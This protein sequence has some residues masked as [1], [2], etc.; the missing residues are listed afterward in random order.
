MIYL[1]VI[2]H[3]VNNLSFCNDVYSDYKIIE[4][5]VPQ[6]SISGPILFLIYINYTNS[7]NHPHLTMHPKDTSLLQVII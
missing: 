2:Y 6:G 3:N 7:I 5:G 4:H 1:K